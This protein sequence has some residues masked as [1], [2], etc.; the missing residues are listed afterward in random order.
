ML[1]VNDKIYFYK[2]LNFENNNGIFVSKDHW[3]NTKQNYKVFAIN[4]LSNKEYFK[5]LKHSLLES[6]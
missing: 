4:V 5:N 1:S 2:N 3:D 6:R